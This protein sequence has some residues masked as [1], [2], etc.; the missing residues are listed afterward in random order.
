ME[1]AKDII[2][3]LNKGQAFKKEK[4]KKTRKIEKVLNKILEHRIMST[5]ISLTI[6]FIVCDIML[7]CSFVNVL[8]KI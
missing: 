7:I 2:L 3:E 1:Y 8:T 4:L 6:G 5:I